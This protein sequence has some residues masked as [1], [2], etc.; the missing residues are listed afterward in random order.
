M[1]EE[2]GFALAYGYC[3]SLATLQESHMIKHSN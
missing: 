2:Q 1:W 3:S